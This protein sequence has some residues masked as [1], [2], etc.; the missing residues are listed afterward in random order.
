MD[1]RISDQAALLPPREA[2]PQVHDVKR[3]AAYDLCC[4]CAAWR[5]T[6]YASNGTYWHGNWRLGDLSISARL[7]TP[8]D[9]EKETR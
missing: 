5:E 4:R 3:Y 8:T 7:C 9:D 1:E 2:E 6:G